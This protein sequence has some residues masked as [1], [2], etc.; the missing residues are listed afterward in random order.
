MQWIKDK[1]IIT[2]HII[3]NWKIVPEEW[4]EKGKERDYEILFGKKRP[5]DESKTEE[6]TQ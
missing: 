4:W 6:I 2:P 5:F 3:G 1:K